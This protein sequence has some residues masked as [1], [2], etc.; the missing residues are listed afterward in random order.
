MRGELIGSVLVLL[1][2]LILLSLLSPIKGQITTALIDGLHSLFGI[3]VWIVPL[4]LGGLG[5]WLAL[6]DVTEGNTMS[7]WRLV[8]ALG[9]FLV[10]EGFATLIAGIPASAQEAAKGT[11]GGLLGWLICGGL[12]A[13][14]GLPLTIIVL[15]ILAAISVMALAGVTLA[16]LNNRLA[17]FW[18][19]IHDRSRGPEGE[20][21]SPRL[22]LGR[23]PYLRRWWRRVTAPRVQ[24][25]VRPP[26]VSANWVA[27]P[28]TTRS[29]AP[30]VRTVAP[31]PAAAAQPRI[32]GGQ[33]WQ[34]PVLAEILEDSSDQDIQQEDIRK[35]MQTIENT[36]AGFG[37]PV[38]VVEVNQ[39]P[40]VTQFGLRPG[41]IVRRD[42]KGE[43]KV[44]KVRVSQIQALA[45][46]L[47]LALA[48]SPIRIEAPVPGRD[49]VGIE[50][51]NVQISL[52]S[53][54][55]VMDSEEWGAT[56]GDLIFGLGRDV[57]G[58]ATVAD[59]VRMPHLLIAGATG[60]GKS[61][62]VNAI[63]TSLL[64]THTPDTLRFLMIDPKRVELTVY[65]G[66]PHLIAP[67]VVDVERALPV[68]QWATREMERRYKE[69]SKLSARNIDSYNEKL[70]ARGEPVLPFIVILIDELADLMLSAPDDVER[71]I[72]R[73]AQMARAT[74]IHLVLATQR[75]SVDVVTGLIKANFPARIAFSVTSQVDSRVI[76]DTPGA[77]QL[78][79]RGDML[80][81]APDTSKL[82]RLQGC[83]VSDHEAHRLVDY[84]KGACAVTTPPDLLTTDEGQAETATPPVDKSSAS[85]AAYDG[86]ALEPPWLPG[87]E[88][89]QQPLWDEIAAAEA[90]AAGT[91]D[92]YRQAVEE[93]RKSGKASISLLQRK[94]RIG[95]SRA[96]RMIDQMEAEGVIGPEASGSRGREV[97]PAP[98]TDENG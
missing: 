74:G 50:V 45:N 39:G 92:M 43:E 91:D 70:A 3:G 85:P 67:V 10:F 29:V 96:A 19:G 63:I 71:S 22:P 77:E 78:L 24:A 72:C 18:R 26:L 27:S 75:P 9:L 84:W 79:G 33:A 14:L 8:G 59:L 53:L 61:V 40:A 62:C 15:L 87:Q 86:N 58:Q 56:K 66:I 54:R 16:D 98:P 30:G 97:L 28:Q 80:F 46:D 65:N 57:S 12:S 90:T 76:L 69:F 7:P 64:L 95:Y 55:G 6:R 37:V 4:L 20:K 25:P 34:L 41:T 73:I 48:A 81:M 11:G 89:L 44:I 1:A 21:I 35:R 38:S 83:F 49:F 88:T 47:S 82:Q 2:L 36:L 31:Q 93:V 17:A 94:L 51:P 5:V 68:L 60:S 23:E 13:I 32:V 52:V 42:R